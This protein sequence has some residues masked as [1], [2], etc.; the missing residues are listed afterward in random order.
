MEYLPDGSVRIPGMMRAHKAECLVPFLMNGA[1]TV[2]GCVIKHMSCIPKEGD[3]LIIA[4]RV[5]V[6]EKMDHNRVSS[7]LLLPP[8]KKEDEPAMESGVES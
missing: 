5:L 7:I 2:G 3:R 6:V 1:T 4:G 8:E